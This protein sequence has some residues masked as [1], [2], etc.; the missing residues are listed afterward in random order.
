M[1]VLAYLVCLCSLCFSVIAYSEE[2]E[3]PATEEVAVE[4]EPVTEE[5]TEEVKEEP[6]E[7]TES[8]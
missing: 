7:T 3:V 1:K 8:G 4:A 5:A 2:T 6:V